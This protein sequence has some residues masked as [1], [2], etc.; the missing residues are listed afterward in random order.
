MDSRNR[1]VTAELQRRK[2]DPMLS[3]RLGLRRSGHGYCPVCEKLVELF[4]FEAAAGL[5]H[6]DL[7]DVEDLAGQFILHRVHNRRGSVM[8]CSISLFDCFE[9]RRTRRLDLPL[10]EFAGGPPGR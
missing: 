8:I 3:A 9:S 5:F 7:R 2:T 4:T 6:T 1:P 10:A